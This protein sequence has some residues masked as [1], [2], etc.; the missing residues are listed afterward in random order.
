MPIHTLT[1]RTRQRYAN[2]EHPHMLFW[3]IYLNNINL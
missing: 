2:D 1:V 3:H